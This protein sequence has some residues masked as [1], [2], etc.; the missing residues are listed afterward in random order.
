MGLDVYL[1][2]YDVPLEV[3]DKREEDAEKL[4][5]QLGKQALTEMKVGSFEQLPEAMHSD[6]FARK[7]ELQVAAGL[8]EY[9]CVVGDHEKI[10]I[11][12]TKYSEHYF[13]IGY[14]R[15]SYNGGGINNVARRVGLG[16]LYDIFEPNDRYRFVPDWNAAFGRAKTWL[17]AWIEQDG[18]RRGV[19]VLIAEHN[20]FCDPSQSPPSENAALELYLRERDR[21]S[22]GWYG[23]REGEFFMSDP[24]RVRALIPGIHNS[25]AGPRPC[26][27][28]VYER[29][30]NDKE[31]DEDWYT[32][33]IE[34]VIETIEF[35][36]SQPNP[37]QYAL[38]WSS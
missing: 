23:S 24:P 5:E 3:F 10:E 17:A 15:S 30:K 36:L 21:R 1:Y 13:K 20:P 34:I 8:D 6:Y 37:Q 31:N 16:D 2:R 26:V 38:H 29:D 27:Y 7:R 18:R 9:G 33:A 35:V 22:D 12:S 32:Q 4:C 28:V 25:F 19:D 14:F 11:D